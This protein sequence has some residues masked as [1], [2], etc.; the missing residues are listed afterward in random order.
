MPQLHIASTSLLRL[1][2]EYLVVADSAA[3]NCLPIATTAWCATTTQGFYVIA[4]TQGGQAAKDAMGAA[5]ATNGVV[6]ALMLTFTFPGLL[7]PPDSVTGDVSGAGSWCGMPRCQV[8]GSAA[9]SRCAG[10]GDQCSLR[11]RGC[12]CGV[13]ARSHARPCL[14]DPD[15]TSCLHA[16][17]LVRCW[18]H[19]HA[20]PCA[21][22]QHA[23][24]M[25][26]RVVRWPAVAD[27]RGLIVASSTHI[28]EHSAYRDHTPAAG[29]GPCCC[30]SSN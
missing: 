27:Q 25:Q 28:T 23:T 19:A 17:W 21:A 29:L 2:D 7:S 10:A 6:A 5:I 16:T 26:T 13:R 24:C 30:P 4:R 1:P 22:V 12:S 14:P 11:L 18:A 8:G 9:S 15:Y 20:T 3:C